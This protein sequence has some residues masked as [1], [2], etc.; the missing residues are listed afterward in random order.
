MLYQLSYGHK[1][2]LPYNS[3][4]IIA[5]AHGFVKMIFPVSAAFLDL[6]HDLVAE[7]LQRHRGGL[8]LAAAHAHGAGFGLLGTQHQHIGGPVHLLGFA[9]LVADLFIGL[10]QHG[11]HAGF[12]QG[13][14][15]GKRPLVSSIR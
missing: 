11:A 8:A 7:F 10:V 3:L 14:Q 6:G 13:L 9:D 12:L 4:P 15:V 2:K 5:G 1:S